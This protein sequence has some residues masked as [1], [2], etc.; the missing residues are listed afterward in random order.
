MRRREKIRLIKWSFC[1]SEDEEEW[2]GDEFKW[3]FVIERERFR[4]EE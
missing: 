4:D 3:W 1:F 2:E